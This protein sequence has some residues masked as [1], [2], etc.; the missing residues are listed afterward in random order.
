MLV[1]DVVAASVVEGLKGT[2]GDAGARVVSAG[3]SGEGVVVVAVSLDE[4][5][6]NPT[7]EIA[8]SSVILADE[9]MPICRS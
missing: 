6:A 9:V 8:E 7:N 5:A 3:G 1:V 4:Q 2:D